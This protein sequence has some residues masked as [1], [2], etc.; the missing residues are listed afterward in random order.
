MSLKVIELFAGVGGF[1]LACEAAGARVV[2][3]NQWEPG[4][5]SQIAS[6]IY[7]RHFGTDAH[8]NEDIA[9]VVTKL[10]NDFNLLPAADLVVGGFPCQDYSV[11]KSKSKSFGIQGKKGVLWWEIFELLRIKSPKH[12]LLENV[13]RLLSSP[14]NQRGR[15]FAVM[16]EGLVSL[17]Y[18][19]EWKVVNA[20][21]YGYPQRRKRVFIYATRESGVSNFSNFASAQSLLFRAFPS[22]IREQI[23]SFQLMGNI[24]ETSE[25]FN[26]QNR[27][28]AF[29]NHGVCRQ[30]E[31]LMTKSV[32]EAGQPMRLGDVLVNPKE[33][34]DSYWI[35]PEDLETWQFLKGAK[36]VRRVSRSSGYE[37]QYKEGKMA[38]PD[39]LDTPSRTIV[40][41]E[42]GK[43]PSRFKHVVQQDGRYRRLVPI[44]LER[45]NGFPDD[46]TSKTASGSPVSDTKRAFLMGNALVI[47]AVERIIR[48]IGCLGTKSN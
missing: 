20:A 33:V 42:G 17:G 29:E 40:T 1:R 13:D 44:E 12:V 21:D 27:S 15:D 38:F 23:R 34:S 25:T 5:K 37:Y 41:G 22:E 14:S 19:V 28:R 30:G 7:T 36:S 46:W 48:Q 18:E 3:S 32:A 2:W 16:L 45:L 6:D 43:S 47:G 8:S 26:S 11:A 24:V 35:A 39:S 31:V 10:Q 9:T 4:Q